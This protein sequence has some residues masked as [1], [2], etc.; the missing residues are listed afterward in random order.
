M[1]DRCSFRQGEAEEPQLPV[2]KVH[3]FPPLHEQRQCFLLDTL[4]TFSR[5]SSVTPDQKGDM[6]ECNKYVSV[7]DIG[8][9]EGSLL[10][11]L[12]QPTVSLPLSSTFGQRYGVPTDAKVKS[13]IDLY[14]P[15]FIKRLVGLDISEESLRIAD[16][17]VKVDQGVDLGSVSHWYKPRPR[18]SDLKV[19]LWK[20]GLEQ[21]HSTF[22]SFDAIF[23]TEVIEHLPPEVL[24]C[25][26]P[27]I[28]GRYSPYI[29]AITTPNYEFNKLFSPADQETG[30]TSSEGGQ[31]RDGGYLDPTGRTSRV[32]RHLDH[33]FE[34]TRDEFRDWCEENAKMWG[35]KVV[36]SGVGKSEERDPWGRDERD[37]L[38]TSEDSRE[39]SKGKVGLFATQTAVFTRILKNKE[40]HEKKYAGRAAQVLDDVLPKSSTPMNHQLFA[41]Y[42]HRAHQSISSYKSPT[43][44]DDILEAV[45]QAM[46]IEIGRNETDISDLWNCDDVSIA[47]QGKLENLY[48]A[49]IQAGI[50]VLNEDQPPESQKEWSWVRPEE[51]AAWARRIRWNQY[52]PL[53]TSAMWE[54]DVKCDETINPETEKRGIGWATDTLDNG[55]PQDESGGWSSSDWEPKK[56]YS[57]EESG[58]G[59]PTGVVSQG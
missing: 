24:E 48:D 43:A 50:D 47:C 40:E 41:E 8:C 1:G 35:Y 36:I 56:I 42:V 49:F 22:Q 54:S 10:T 29:L 45:Q 18:W 46:R 55:W 52:V 13:T 44:T 33:K 27:M 21:F 14:P 57:I 30:L 53:E 11:A 34:W 51:C 38:P 26:C 3:F 59:A 12:H 2:P 7:L 5:P 32:F 20:G 39:Q 4:A 9:G 16:E 28:L 15:R 37:S 25:F 23:S 31:V 19:E 17:R 58:W 6:K